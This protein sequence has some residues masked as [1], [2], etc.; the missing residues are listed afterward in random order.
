MKTLPKPGNA[1]YHRY[2][3]FCLPVLYP[4]NINTDTHR[5]IILVV[6]LFG[7]E[8]WS[9]TLRK[10]FRLRVFENRALRE[11]FG[12]MKDK[13]TGKWRRLQ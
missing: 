5:T 7:C 10:E 9:L 4:K 11:I 12:P 13:A 1:C 6:V 8:S 2:R 3:I